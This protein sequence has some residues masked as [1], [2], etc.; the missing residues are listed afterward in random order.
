[1]KP[2]SRA[3]K[4][5]GSESNEFVVEKIIGKRFVRGHPQVLVKWV[6]FPI[7]ESTWEP[8]VNMGNCMRLLADFEA[9]LFERANARQ[10]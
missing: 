3:N 2:N 1:M 4:N 7:C 9:Q 5:N 10:E 6:G 8:M